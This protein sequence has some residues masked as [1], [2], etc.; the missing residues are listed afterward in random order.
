MK[1][2]TS[3]W[4]LVP[5]ILMAGCQAMTPPS[6]DPVLIKLEDLEQRLEAI[7]RVMQNQSLVNMT[8][9]VSA[10]ERRADELQGVTET[11]DHDAS[12]TADRQR[13]LYADFDDRI[14]D[15]EANMQARNAPSVLDGGKLVPGQLPVPGGSDRDN[16]QAAFELV[17]EQRYEP[18]AL[19]FKQ[20]LVSFPDS[21]LAANAQYWL[22]ESYYVTQE[23]DAA[24]K[25]FQ[26]VIKDY[27]RSSKVA[28]AL[29][30][31]G[32]CNYEL[33]RWDE[34]KVSL[35]RVQEDY[36]NT[37]AA[38]LAAQRLKRMETEGV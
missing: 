15:L 35:L 3:L 26:L 11:L 14:R 2:N 27:P 23:F 18:A 17:K 19:A 9:Q 33:K 31:T 6:E 8:Q 7:E 25:S 1:I 16:Y 32:Y 24:L 22:A 30:K 21:D 13:Q 34:A 10:L 36:A 4:V 37:T 20:F 5:V 12:E 38:R 29:L 28:D